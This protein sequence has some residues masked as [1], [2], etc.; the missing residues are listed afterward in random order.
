MVTRDRVIPIIPRPEFQ[1]STVVVASGRQCTGDEQ[2][3]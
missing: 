2:E 1:I 3:L